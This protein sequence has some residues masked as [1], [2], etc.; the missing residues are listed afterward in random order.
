MDRTE[1]KD[2]MVGLWQDLR[3][4]LRILAKNRGFTAVAVLTLAIGIGASTAMFSVIECGILNPFPYAHSH[5]MAVVVARYRT[6]GSGYWWG[7]FPREEF[8]EFRA[9]NHVFEQVMGYRHSDCLF[10]GGEEALDL[11][12]L[13]TTGNLFEFTGVRPWLGRTFNPSDA[14]PGSS[15]VAVL[16]YTT[17]QSKFDG[18]RKIV[19]RRITLNNKS[20]AIIGVMPPRFTFGDADLWVPHDFAAETGA[21]SRRMI[22]LD[23]LL[24][25]GVSFGQAAAEIRVLAQRFAAIHPELAPTGFYKGESLSVESLLDAARPEVDKLLYLLFAAVGLVLAIACGNVANLLLARA[26]TRE[27]EI[28]IRAALGA[29][30]TRLARQFMLESLLLASAGG[31]FGALFAWPALRALMA[32][33]PAGYIVGEAVIRINGPVLLFAIAVAFVSTFLFGLAPA[34]YAG[35]KDFQTSLNT[36][37]MAPAARP[38]YGT[39]W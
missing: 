35:R 37:V 9:H 8:L 14:S 5:R 17:W 31:L 25:P 12:C 16:R 19:G 13:E 36:A 15:P 38:C 21:E 10:T 4:G 34:L 28:G 7:W 39:C 6:T 30:R 3:Y 20:V 26:T 29:G 2:F 27:G 32:A 18:D 23:G 24:K 22:S 33:M 11:D 1:G